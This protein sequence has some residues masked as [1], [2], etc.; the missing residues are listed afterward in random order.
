MSITIA[1]ASTAMTT[2]AHAGTLLLE[3]P[4]WDAGAVWTV[5]V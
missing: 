1:T 2:H 3:L 4:V 5:V